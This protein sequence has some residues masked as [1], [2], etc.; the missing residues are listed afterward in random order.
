M[1]LISPLILS[2]TLALPTLT[3]AA[4][5]LPAA[6]DPRVQAITL[7]TAG[8]AMIDATGETGP[9]G[10]SLTLS[11][12]DIDDF[13]KSV[14]ISDPAA[15]TPT[16]R[17]RGPGAFEDA[18]ATLPLSP[19][20]VTD[21]AQLLRAM[22]GAPVIVDRRGTE[23]TGTIMGVSDR[24]CEHGPCPVLAVQTDT[25]AVVQFD[26]ADAVTFRFAEATD[27]AML[28]T[29]LA[30]FRGQANPRRLTVQIGSADTATRD[31]DLTWL[32]A[33]PTWKTAWR[34][35]DTPEGLQLTGWAVVENATGHDWDDVTLTLA[36]G[37][38]RALSADLY[39]RTMPARDEGMPAP[40]MEMSTQMARGMADS[41]PQ[42]ANTAPAAMK[43]DDGQSFSRFTLED[44]VTLA[45]GQ[46]LSLPFLQET[47]TDARITLYRGGTGTQ[48]PQIALTLTNPLPLRLPA[49][50][51][52][53]Y[54]DG[55]GH[56]GDALIPELAPMA[57]E[58]VDFAT[59]TAISVREEVARTE[60][61][62]QMRIANGI[63]TLTE[64]LR[65]TTTYNITGA[66][67]GARD[68]TL[69]H[70][71][72]DGWTVTT[73]GGETTLDDTR[74]T[75][76]VAADAQMGFDVVETRPQRREVALT[77]MDATTLARWQDMA[78]DAE[79]QALLGEIRSLRSE[80]TEIGVTLERDAAQAEAL[81][82]EQSRLVDLIVALGDDS[83]AN[84][85]RRARVDAID[86]ELMAL[87]AERKTLTDRQ[88]ARQSDLRALIGG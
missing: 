19:H 45:P 62:A 34:A 50:I 38:V 8:I 87:A 68:L 22:T 31:L 48:H 43:A 5:T 79:T 81:E 53:L 84:T 13:L 18:F 66:A 35:V 70:P 56:A 57:T 24:A 76:S 9:D 47:L 51:L 6:A 54:E 52:T 30:A 21:P 2:A 69:A 71:L 78:P 80:L 41:A 46:M 20:E 64:D 55:R 3:L 27:R 15:A 86:A 63:L 14:W 82:A 60:T 74:W 23:T 10:L 1:R 11:R 75:L 44:P 88:A 59:D 26:L 73:E 4:L 16:L 37:S 25:G 49:G 58:T 67:D 32:Q 12:D 39:G 61:I 36:T 29:A 17:L 28:E 83:A 72:R 42:F 77:G 65:T 33:A 7:S 85:D 40:V